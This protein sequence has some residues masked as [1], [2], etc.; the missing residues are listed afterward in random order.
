MDQTVTQHE[1]E[2]GNQLT[3]MLDDILETKSQ[4]AES[5]QEEESN[6]EAKMDTENTD[7]TASTEDEKEESVQGVSEE[8]EDDKVAKGDGEEEVKEK[9]VPKEEPKEDDRDMLFKELDDL[10]KSKMSQPVQQQVQRKEEDTIDVTPPPKPVEEVAPKKP[11]VPR[12]DAIG[13][14]SNDEYEDVVTDPVRFNEALN[15]VYDQAI[16]Y[17]T[18]SIPELV[19]N[20][21]NRQAN[22]RQLVDDFY[23][24]N[25]DLVP[26]K[27]YVGYVANELQAKHPDWPYDKLLNEVSV[28]V[29]KRLNTSKRAEQ[30]EA[31]A[32]VARPAFAKK[33]GTKGRSAVEKPLNELEGDISELIF[34]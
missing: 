21:V 19:G 2:Q 12:A 16:R 33:P 5:K 18:S 25:S 6:E 24:E 26:M 30:A 14:V 9:E 4:E 8:K 15:R 22:M 34:N 7:E 17:M 13:F 28:D 29:R 20:L 3:D 31:A 27:N 32:Q 1:E 11:A 23:K 10:A